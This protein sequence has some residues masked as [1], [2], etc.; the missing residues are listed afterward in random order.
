M[1]TNTESN[2]NS[3]GT[4]QASVPLSPENPLTKVLTP[5][6]FNA[7][8][9][10]YEADQQLTPQD[11]TEIKKDFERILPRISIA[12]NVASLVGFFSLT[13]FKRLSNPVQD[14]TANPNPLKPRSFIHKPFLSFLCGLGGLVLG[15]EIAGKQQF[16]SQIVRL[17]GIPEKERQLGVWKTIERHQSSMFYLYYRRTSEDP[18]YILKDPREFTA[19]QKHE[20]H[21]HPPSPTSSSKVFRKD[22]DRQVIDPVTKD[23]T[24]WERVRVANGY[25]TNPNNSL[26]TSD[27]SIDSTAEFDGG[28]IVTTEDESERTIVP[29]SAWERIR[30][31]SK[32]S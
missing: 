3:N 18:S 28:E 2:D 30:K 8:V 1:S 20:V 31:S 21:Y 14:L 32:S 4:S 23:L 6:Q 24:V 22:D 19:T 15:G 7:S 29:T 13:V 26:E 17:Q 27:T 12:S 9:H 11:R 10:F 25:G 5:A 16:N